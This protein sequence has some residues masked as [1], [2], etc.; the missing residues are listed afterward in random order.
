MQLKI[1][2]ILFGALVLATLGLI[3]FG[4][5]TPLGHTNYYWA[6]LILL[7]TSLGILAP[8]SLKFTIFQIITWII[9]A[10]AML[11]NF[12]WFFVS[13][14][15][16][17]LYYSISNL[18]IMFIYALFF[19]LMPVYAIKFQGK[20]ER[21]SIRGYHVHENLIG[22]LLIVS[23]PFC[24]FT[25]WW[26]WEI[27]AWGINFLKLHLLLY[28]G[29]FCIIL[30]GFLIGRDHKDIIKL[31]FIEKVEARRVNPDF[32]NRKKFYRISPFGIAFVLFG[33]NLLFHNWFWSELF[34]FKEY[35]F[36]T[37]GFILIICGAIIGGLNPSYFA[38]K[39]DAP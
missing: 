13:T 33:I 38:N 24:V 5:I 29:V 12:F 9:F 16:Y 20:Y 34:F 35:F 1:F 4:V 36:I 15:N 25:G 39:G 8:F 28:F 14:F 10:T 37:M 22:I 2:W 7:C 32:N 31:K 30:G 11:A 17:V 27:D 21:S 23:G 6:T 18:S 19:T 26:W 3:Y